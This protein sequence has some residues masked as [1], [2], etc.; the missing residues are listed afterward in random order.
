MKKALLILLALALVLTFAAGCAQEPA[1][2]P[3]D[4]NTDANTERVTLTVGASPTPHAEILA[5][6]K[7]ILAEQDIDLVIKE[8]NALCYPQHLC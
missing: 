5:A 6:T 7:D 1:D 8:F 4:P 3:D 2:N